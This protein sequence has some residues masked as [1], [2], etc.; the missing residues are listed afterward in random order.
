MSSSDPRPSR[1]KLLA[2]LA[3]LPLAACG[4]QPAYAPGGPAEGLQNSISFADPTDKN[5]FDLVERFEERLGRPQSARFALAYVIEATP[6]GVGITPE[7]AITRFDV[8]G[9]VTY[10]ITDIA[11]A[12]VVSTGAVNSFTAYSA[13]G[14]TVST[15]AAERDAAQRLMRLLADQI[16]TRLIATSASWAG[17]RALSASWAGAG[18][19]SANGAGDRAP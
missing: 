3:T 4:F 15:L 12:T 7:N 6:S 1:R 17:D 18:T 10:R 16:V 5:S 19:P 8:I 9:T 2:L 13:T 11:S 14:T